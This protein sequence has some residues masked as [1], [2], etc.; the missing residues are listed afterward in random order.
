MGLVLS[1][2]VRIPTFQR[3]LKWKAPDVVAL[4]ESLYLGYPVGS[5]LFH[6]KPAIEQLLEIGPLHVAGPEI[7]EA[8]WVVDGQQ[9]LMSLAISLR[10]PT[11]I[12]T[13]PDDAWV[14]YFDPDSLRFLS[15][16]D[17][18]KIPD[19]WVPLAE[20]LDAS[21]LSE[22]VFQWP[23]SRDP[24]L[25]KAVFEA[26]SLIR[27]YSLP[28][29]TVE[30]DDAAI[31]REI[32]LRV[33][34]FGKPLQW[35]EIHDALYGSTSQAEAPTRL[36]E[37][38]DALMD[39]GMGRPKEQ[40][41]LLR[42]LIAYEGHDVTRNFEDIR[43]QEPQFLGGTAAAA[44][45]TLRRVFG[46][47]RAHAK[48][49]HL[50][51]LP[52]SSPLT[53]LTRFFRF[54]PNPSARSRELLTRWLWRSILA[55]RDYDERTFQRRG[56]ADIDPIDEEGSVQKLLEFLPKRPPPAYRLPERFDARDAE[57]RIAMLGL[58]SLEPRDLDSGRP[59]D[60]ASLIEMSSKDAFR[61]IV[62]DGPALAS[63]PAN[64]TILPGAGL[65]RTEFLALEEQTRG[66]FARDAES[67]LRSHALTLAAVT[68]LRVGDHDRFLSERVEL[69]EAQTNTYAAAM[70]DWSANDR[71]SLDYIIHHGVTGVAAHDE[72]V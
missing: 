38:A 11:P 30:T 46:F 47:L 9:R 1:G 49:P 27:E 14:V 17:N 35:D 71:P 48:I 45:P 50:R 69:L 62:S 19:T 26:A 34:K 5:L 28:A 51:L 6:R 18:G 57:S 64:R 37:L 59:L 66:L 24:R 7:D 8:L 60:I 23:H 15:P 44:L 42:C 67:I 3:K 21:N 53:I 56:I 29:Y 36:S 20:I 70:A 68:A 58:C 55:A 31:L 61:H 54:H 16:P 40:A 10:R 33:N 2:K 13:T 52:W 63:S 72:G 39:V 41:Q 43:R 25:R 4:F 12:P 32:F 65:A 22:W